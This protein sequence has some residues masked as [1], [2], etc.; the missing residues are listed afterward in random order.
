MSPLSKMKINLHEIN[1]RPLKGFTLIEILVALVIFGI[2]M[3]LITGFFL[4]SS[5]SLSRNQ[6]KAIV[7][8]EIREIMT[9]MTRY[10]TDSDAF[11]VYTL[12]GTTLDS[13]QGSNGSGELVAFASFDFDTNPANPPVSNIVGYYHSTTSDGDEVIRRFNIAPTS[14]TTDVESEIL[15]ALGDDSTNRIVTQMPPS[16]TS[17]VDFSTLFFNQG[18]KTVRVNIPVYSGNDYEN[19]YQTLQL[20]LHPRS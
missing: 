4:S 16:G 18:D 2:V 15:S 12:T 11:Y 14:T 9:D 20:S 8:Q 1:E 10:G 7:A 6:N 13:L 19:E 3:V 5:R 17:G